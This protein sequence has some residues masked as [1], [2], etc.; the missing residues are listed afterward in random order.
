LK[1][2]FCNQIQLL[3]L[4]PL[5]NSVVPLLRGCRVWGNKDLLK[6][7]LPTEPS[8]SPFCRIIPPALSGI[9]RVGHRLRQ[10]EGPIGR[11]FKGP[12]RIDGLDEV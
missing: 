11:E 5:D 3:S 4:L 7:R 12:L 10:T 9:L 1:F 6:G 2:I 8:A